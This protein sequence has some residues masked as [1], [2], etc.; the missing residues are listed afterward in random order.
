[1]DEKLVKMGL[2]FIGIGCIGITNAYGKYMY[3]K[4]L[5]DAD[6]FYKPVLDADSKLIHTLVEKLQKAE[7]S[8][9]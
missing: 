9:K 4:G 3:S 2:M 5:A 7:E 1:M 8:R 6:K